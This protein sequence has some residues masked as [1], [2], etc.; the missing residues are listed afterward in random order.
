MRQMADLEFGHSDPHLLEGE[1]TLA[2]PFKGGTQA[3][4]S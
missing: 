2:H 3:Q 1:L 4:G